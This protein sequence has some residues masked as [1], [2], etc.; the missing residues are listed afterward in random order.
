MYYT[1]LHLNENNKP[2]YVGK[3]KGNRAYEKR[4]YP[5]LYTV[6]IVHDNISEI[7]TLEFEEFL[8]QEIGIDNLYNTFKKGVISGYSICI[9]YDNTK[10]EL[11]RIL[12]LSTKEIRKHVE[13]VVDDAINGNKKAMSFLIQRCPLDILLRINKLAKKYSDKF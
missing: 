1:Y 13:L 2:I 6:K 11:K 3:G 12:S 8:I 10:Q 5:E 9:D 7:Q 4:N